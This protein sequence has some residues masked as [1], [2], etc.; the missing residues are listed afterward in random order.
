MKNK[1]LITTLGFITLVPM[2]VHADSVVLEETITQGDV[3]LPAYT[4]ENAVKKG[5]T[6]HL[7]DRDMT[8]STSQ[9]IRLTK[10]VLDTYETIQETALNQQPSVFSEGLAMISS[11]TTLKPTGEE[12]EGF[13]EI[14]TPSGLQG[15]VLLDHTQAHTKE[16]PTRPTVYVSK[17]DGINAS[18]AF[19]QKVTL[20]D[21]QDGK[22]ILKN[23]DGKTVNVSR[24]AFSFTQ[25]APPQPTVKVASVG[26][27]VVT[28][29]PTGSLISTAKQY[30]GV[31]YVWGG[32]SPNGFDCS[33]YIQ[34]IYK[35]HGVNLPRT[36][37][38]QAQ[39]GQK[40]TRNQ[41]Q[42]GDLIV[43]ETYKPGPSHAG[44]YLGN[45]QFIHAGGDRVQISSLS[46]S[47]W[48]TRLLYA[49]RL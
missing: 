35:Q 3:S 42:V 1:T 31:P 24:Q 15:W 37:S 17:S 20:I 5:D 45:G 34:Y 16:V 22:F 10:T 2:S 49:K 38:G 18:F 47:Y 13:A 11:E 29:A 44:I 21:S 26:K 9:A 46:T 48:S 6:Y 12:R 28:S 41:L 19:R 43:F 39:Y 8:I 7:V 25:P 33:G 30:L 36:V 14:T 40:V 27:K 32:T 23:D 4:K